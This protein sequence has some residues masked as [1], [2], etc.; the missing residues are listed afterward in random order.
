MDVMH[1]AIAI[2]MIDTGHG[3]PKFLIVQDKRYKEWTFV[4]GGCRVRE[5]YNP[6]RCAI[7]ELEEETRGI[8]HLKRGLYTYFKFYTEFSPIE[9]A[10]YHVYVF[11]MKMKQEDMDAIIDKFTNEKRKMDTNEI[12]FRKNYDENDTISF[13]TLD[14]IKNCSTLWKLIDE[15]VLSNKDFYSALKSE[16]RYFQSI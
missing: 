13:M 6:I 12:V 9:K 14:E 3:P 7:R 5:F 16:C 1:K 8:I 4:T 2:P 10:L 15:N 11:H